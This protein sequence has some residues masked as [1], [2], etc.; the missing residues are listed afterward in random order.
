MKFSTIL[1]NGFFLAGVLARTAPNPLAIQNP[2]S[3]NPAHH[4]R[5]GARSQANLTPDINPKKDCRKKHPKSKSSLS[6]NR[7]GLD[8]FQPRRVQSCEKER[9]YCETD[10]KCTYCNG[11][12]KMI[13]EDYGIC[14]DKPKPP[15]CG[16]TVQ[17]CTSINECVDCDGI[18]KFEKDYDEVGMCVDKPPSCS[19]E[20]TYCKSY[21]D[22]ESCNGECKLQG[23]GDDELGVCVDR[24]DKPETPSCSDT[25]QHCTDVSQCWDCGGI[26]DVQHGEEYGVCVDGPEKQKA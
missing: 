26:C 4:D 3:L 11:I 14:V 7:I 15:S 22:C 2:R 12:C 24:K 10:E 23:E 8:L 9:W 16:D 1:L 17:Y 18:C 20:E 5:S 6:R 13:E 21:L 19:D 25:K